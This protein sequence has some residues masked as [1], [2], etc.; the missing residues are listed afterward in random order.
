M[1][2]LRLV[3]S[4]KTQVS[5]AKEP[6]KRDYNLQNDMSKI[7]TYDIVSEET[8]HVC[9]KYIFDTFSNTCRFKCVKYMF[10][11]FTHTCRVSL[12]VSNTYLTNMYILL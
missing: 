11:T 8:R 6:Y 12:H 5:I 10:D 2:W 4:L 3:G 9:V 7:D 1:R